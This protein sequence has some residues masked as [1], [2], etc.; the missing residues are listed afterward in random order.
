D[1]EATVTAETS[2]AKPAENVN[3]GGARPRDTITPAANIQSDFQVTAAEARTTA[4]PGELGAAGKKQSKGDQFW[5]DVMRE[6]NYINLNQSLEDVM[7]QAKST[8]LR[9][10]A[11]EEPENRCA[12]MSLGE[13]DEDMGESMKN[14]LMDLSSMTEASLF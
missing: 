13:F 11:A 4:A 14:L 8:Y 1:T 10:I 2:Q 7:R 12:I 5:R 9:V 6:V 3:S